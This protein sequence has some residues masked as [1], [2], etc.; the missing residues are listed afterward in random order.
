MN[1]AD[2]YAPDA[3]TTV[4]VWTPAVVGLVILKPELISMP[5]FVLITVKPVCESAVIG[6]PSKV[7]VIASFDLNPEP[8]IA[9]VV[10]EP[11]KFVTVLVVGVISIDGEATVKFVVAVFAESETDRV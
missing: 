8:V 2:A 3:P 11:K 6:A 9:K 5:P 1:V 4:I 10:V 7:T